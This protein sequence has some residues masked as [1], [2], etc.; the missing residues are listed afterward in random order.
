MIAR[1]N[2]SKLATIMVA[3]ALPCAAVGQIFHDDPSQLIDQAIVSGGRIYAI[4]NGEL[5]SFALDG[6]DE[7]DFAVS[8]VIDVEGHHGEVW[9]ARWATPDE[10]NATLLVQR[11]NGQEFE[12]TPPLLMPEGFVTLVPSSDGLLL[13]SNAA[14]YHL[15]NGTWQ[16]KPLRAP[17]RWH[18]GVSHTQIGRELYVGFDNG[19]WGGGLRRIDI[20]TGDVK[21]IEKHGDNPCDGVL[22]DCSPVTSLIQDPRNSSCVLAAVGIRHFL[23]SGAVVQVCGDS[24]RSAYIMRFRDYVFDDRKI[25]MSEAVFGLAPADQGYWVLTGDALYRITGGRRRLIR[26]ALRPSGSLL[27][28][29]PAPEVIVLATDLR[30]RVSVSGTTP[31]LVPVQ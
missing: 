18:N 3:L 5:S 14:I 25:E 8:D 1:S 19:E 10:H 29:R 24:V 22:D 30:A 12:L 16:P 31:I 6:S 26:T 20:D 15:R 17:L 2:A 23:E 28:D 21:E 11:W 7:R 9:I 13:L 27:M 4:S